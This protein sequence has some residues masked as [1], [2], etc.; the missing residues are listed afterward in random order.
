VKVRED[1]EVEGVLQSVE[2]KWALPIPELGVLKSN[3]NPIMRKW[4]EQRLE[5]DALVDAP[6][7][8]EFVSDIQHNSGYAALKISDE[9]RVGACTGNEIHELHSRFQNMEQEMPSISTPPC[10][11][12][13]EDLC[14]CSNT[15]RFPRHGT[16]RNYITRLVG[17]T[18]QKDI[19]LAG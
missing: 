15:L 8:K 2:N 5:P 10:A 14:D 1:G 17:S 4:G 6:S 9:S 16:N 19:R 12:V 3:L 7:A 18:V 13:S 11:W